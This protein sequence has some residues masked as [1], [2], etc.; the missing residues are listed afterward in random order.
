MRS[1]SGGK[2]LETKMFLLSS[3]NLNLALVY[4]IPRGSVF[5]FI[6]VCHFVLHL[7]YPVGVQIYYLF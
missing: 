3:S 7:F 6:W 1:Q 4:D 5:G 2:V